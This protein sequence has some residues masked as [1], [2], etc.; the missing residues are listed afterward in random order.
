MMVE[1]AYLENKRYSGEKLRQAKLTF[2]K[3]S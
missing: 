1:S 2:E 3:I